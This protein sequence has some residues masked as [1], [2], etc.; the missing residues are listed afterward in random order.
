MYLNMLIIKCFTK[1]K[2]K[3]DIL[4]IENNLFRNEDGNGDTNCELIKNKRIERTNQ[5]TNNKII[6]RSNFNSLFLN[7]IIGIKSK[8]YIILMKDAKQ[9]NII[10]VIINWFLFRTEFV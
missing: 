5:L 1:Y 3:S 8:M 9:Q 4:E 10:K 2:I 6:L 7:K